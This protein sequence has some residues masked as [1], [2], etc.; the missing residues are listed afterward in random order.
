MAANS[1]TRRPKNARTSALNASSN[2]KTA[3]PAPAAPPARCA[4]PPKS[5]DPAEAPPSQFPSPSLTGAPPEPGDPAHRRGRSAAVPLP[6]PQAAA[7][8]A[9]NPSAKTA[10]S[11][12]YRPVHVWVKI[13]SP[14]DP[15][16]Q[17]IH[18]ANVFILSFYLCGSPPINLLLWLH[19]TNFGKALQ[20]ECTLRLWE[21][22]MFSFEKIADL[23]GL[24]EQ[25]ITDIV[26]SFLMEEGRTE[27]ETEKVIQAYRQ[28]FSA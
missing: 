17:N 5:T 15:E 13:S 9:I 1:R 3:P 11:P 8:A 12:A 4:A 23:V 14:K 21:M 22:Q 19:A 24:P 27:A 2:F 28:K 16:K 25:E 20:R 6:P 10:L 26:R 7:P 18:S